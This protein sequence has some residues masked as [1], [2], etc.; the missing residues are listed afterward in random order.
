VAQDEAGRTVP[1]ERASRI[2]GV[3][4]GV[5]EDVRT[6]GSFAFGFVGW[7]PTFADLGRAV[8]AYSETQVA[9]APLRTA[10]RVGRIVEVED[11]EG[12][13][14]LVVVDLGAE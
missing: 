5:S 13:E 11:T 10:L 14:P 12:G 3:V 7:R 8:W 6:A 4:D 1:V 2:A 9:G